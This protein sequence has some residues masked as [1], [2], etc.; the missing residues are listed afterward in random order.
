MDINE[1]FQTIDEGKIIFS[2]SFRSGLLIRLKK[3]KMTI[4]E[5]EEHNEF[6]IFPLIENDFYGYRPGR[7]ALR[8]ESGGIRT[9]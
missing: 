6:L 2:I 9:Q 8:K 7:S 5:E 4:I 1:L 3:T